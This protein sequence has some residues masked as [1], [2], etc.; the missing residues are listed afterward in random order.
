MSIYSLFHIDLSAVAHN[1]ATVQNRVAPARLFGVVKGDAYGLGLNKVGPILRQAGAAGLVINDVKEA[2]Q[3][4]EHGDMG[5]LLCV[6]PSSTTDIDRL[7]AMRVTLSV[8]DLIE[9]DRVA[10]RARTAGTEAS[11]H[12]EVDTGIGRHG[13]LPEALGAAMARLMREEGLHVAGAWTHLVDTSDR[14]QSYQQLTRFLEV[15]ASM[16]AEVDRHI[17][18]SGGLRL[19]RE[20]HLDAVRPGLALYG[21]APGLEQ[22]GMALRQV[23]T[24]TTAVIGIVERR[25]GTSVGYNRA[26]RLS[27]DS[28]LGYLPIGFAHGYPRLTR[29]VVAIRG[30]LVPIVGRVNMQG[31]LVDLTDVPDSVVGDEVTLVG[32]PEPSVATLLEAS[33]PAMIPNLFSCGRTKLTARRYSGGT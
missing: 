2:K 21:L 12:L 28:R 33:E 20:Y 17:C 22:A 19:G 16:P 24:W 1:A 3:L 5:F 11:V 27:R 29:G 14:E 4:R 13:F 25:A 8:G 9:L 18:N 26:S 7:L 23:I 6:A 31:M 32:S 15:T 30:R 10:I